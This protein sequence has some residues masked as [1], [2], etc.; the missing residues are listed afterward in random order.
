MLK[1]GITGGIGSGKSTIA[2]A[3]KSLGIPVYDADLRAKEIM[4]EDADLKAAIQTNF[5]E[6]LYADGELDRAS[7]AALVFTDKEKLENLNSIVHPAVAL[8]FLRWSEQKKKDGH[9]IIA[10]EAALLVEAG[11]YKELD[12]LILVVAPLEERI[13]RVQKRNS[14]TENQVRDRISKQLTD[15]EKAPFA[16]LVLNNNNSDKVLEPLLDFIRSLE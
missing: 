6:N 9:R 14:W 13:E 15:E 3:L 12:K 1:I 2:R 11:S 4:N 8:D 10:K 5:G 7:L 16:D